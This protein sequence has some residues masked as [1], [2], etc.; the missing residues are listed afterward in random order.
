[1]PGR[2]WMTTPTCTATCYHS[3][4]PPCTC[5]LIRQHFGGSS[6]PP[7]LSA[8]MPLVHMSAYT[9]APMSTCPYASVPKEYRD[10]PRDP[11]MRASWCFCVV[12]LSLEWLP[13]CTRRP[14]PT[15]CHRYYYLSV[16]SGKSFTKVHTAFHFDRMAVHPRTQGLVLA[17][18]EDT[19]RHNIH[20]R[21]R[22]WPLLPCSCACFGH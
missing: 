9:H 15:D 11:E 3:P 17:T 12:R 6:L 18:R 4:P 13:H 21:D 7:T 10:L 16:D 8:H 2:I 1:M 19:V 20:S 14:L 5:A 22:S